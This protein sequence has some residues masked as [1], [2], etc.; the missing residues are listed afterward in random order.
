MSSD[1]ELEQPEDRVSNFQKNTLNRKIIEEEREKENTQ[2]HPKIIDDKNIYEEFCNNSNSSNFENLKIEELEKIYGDGDYLLDLYYITKKQ[3]PNKTLCKPVT[4]MQIQ[5]IMGNAIHAIQ[6][7]RYEKEEDISE[8]IKDIGQQIDSAKSEI[9]DINNNV[10]NI[11]TTIISLV[12]SISVINSAIVG[13]ENI[14][15]NYII[16]F[17]SSIIF[18]GMLIIFFIYSIHRKDMPIKSIILLIMAFAV[19]VLL[20]IASMYKWIDISKDDKNIINNN[21][22]ESI[23]INMEKGDSNE[24]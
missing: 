7:K 24:L 5:Y 18:F 6:N 2:E 11:I 3:N 1:K 15:P 21:E 17:V 9:K 20:W 13:I 14:S 8:H 16:P 10:N 19:T 22:N 4:I 12:L 23:N